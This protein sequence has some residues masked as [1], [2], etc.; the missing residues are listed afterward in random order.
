MIRHGEQQLRQARWWQVVAVCDG[1]QHRQHQA[2]FCSC[3]HH[4]R[5]AS[6]SALCL[7]CQVQCV[8]SGVCGFQAWCLGYGS[9]RGVDIAAQ[10]GFWEL[11]VPLRYDGCAVGRTADCQHQLQPALE[12]VEQPGPL[13]AGHV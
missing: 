4:H 12:D 7:K 5:H 2:S 13:R 1:P 10:L 8:G 6:K 9:C 11:H 3:S